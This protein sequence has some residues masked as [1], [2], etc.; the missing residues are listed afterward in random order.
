VGHDDDDDDDIYIYINSTFHYNLENGKVIWVPLH[1]FF[2][3]VNFHNVVTKL[4][5]RKN[6]E[7]ILFYLKLKFLFY[8]KCAKRI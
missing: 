3:A 6:R 7:E 1:H 2:L 8:Q 5:F 4:G